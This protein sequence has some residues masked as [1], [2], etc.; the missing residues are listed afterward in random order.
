M[1]RD[2]DLIKK[3]LAFVEEQ[4]SCRNIPVPD[5]CGYTEDQIHYH[6]G[7]CH[8]AGYLVAGSPGTYSTGRRFPEILYMTW[9]GHEA[10]ANLRNGS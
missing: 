4:E 2:M 10:L 5:L 7:L 8:E 3:I 9:G 6:V 1:R